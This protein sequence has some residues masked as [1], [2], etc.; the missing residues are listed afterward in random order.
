MSDLKCTDFLWE[1]GYFLGHLYIPTYILR[2]YYNHNPTYPYSFVP[3]QHPYPEVH[4]SEPG[5]DTTPQVGVT[6]FNA[7]VLQQFLYLLC[8]IPTIEKV[9]NAFFDFCQGKN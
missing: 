1:N 4:K 8:R 5:H 2:Q 9:A 3:V 6:Y 7:I